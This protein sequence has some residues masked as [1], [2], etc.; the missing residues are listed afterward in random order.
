MLSS[1]RVISGHGAYA[2]AIASFLFAVQPM[3]QPQRQKAAIKTDI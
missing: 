3:T 1:K 2:V